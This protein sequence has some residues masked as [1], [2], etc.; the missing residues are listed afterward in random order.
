M[1]LEI[2]ILLLQRSISC[3]ILSLI[4]DHKRFFCICTLKRANENDSEVIQDDLNIRHASPFLCFGCHSPCGIL[5]PHLR[6]QKKNGHKQAI[7][8]EEEKYDKQT[9]KKMDR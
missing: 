2:S 9:N 1:K 5:E 7:K 4:T 6:V 3:C 8:Q